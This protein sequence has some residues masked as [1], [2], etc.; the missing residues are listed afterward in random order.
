MIFPTWKHA[1]KWVG[2][3]LKS[4]KKSLMRIFSIILF[5]L[6]VNSL[7]VGQ[8]RCAVALNEAQDKYDQGRLYEVPELISSC[9]ENGFTKEQKI[10]AYRLLTLTYLF[11]N[12][13][14]K[15]DSAYLEL[16]KL[17]PEYDINDD[18]D[19]ME[20]INHH[21][22]FTTKPIYYLTLG[23]F[24][25]NVS[26]ANILTDYS[27]SLSGNESESF[28]TVLGFH[29]GLGAEMVLYRNLHLYGEIL[30][31]SKT[32]HVTDT[33]WDFY[34]TNI[35]LAQTQVEIPI[36][37]KYNFPMGKVSPFV[38][39][40]ISPAFIYNSS[41]QNIEGV[42]FQNSEEFPVQPRPE[43]STNKLTTSFNYS[44]ILGVG[45]NYKI[46]L[47][48]L[49]FEARYSMEMLNATKFENRWR[50]DVPDYQEGR[51]LKFPTGYVSDDL[52]LNNL[53]FFIGFV[54]PLY[55]PRK[56]K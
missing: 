25:L 31:T 27:I 1:K 49:S 55:K 26:Y 18:L 41:I 11:L 14:E 45:I 51:D 7:A 21:D 28:S 39:G 29:V 36:L 5:F 3:R 52:K 37:L 43:I 34:T 32:I 20:I 9:I 30:F 4:D 8:D 24:G 12:Y 22:K 40:G 47:N 6:F 17:S 10:T 50:E 48:Y 15:A 42:Y 13:F 44:T 46:G 16:L 35:N 53:S 33:H 2:K 54:K 38:Q 19:P 56:I 23:K